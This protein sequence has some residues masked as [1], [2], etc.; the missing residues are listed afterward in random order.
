MKGLLF[1]GSI[2]ITVRVTIRV[3]RIGA[4]IVR[5]GFWGPARSASTGFSIA[6]NRGFNA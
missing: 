6:K 1:K 3:Y 5:V 2:W 4:S